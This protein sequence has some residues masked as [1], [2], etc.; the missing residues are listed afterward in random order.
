MKLPYRTRRALVTL[1]IIGLI[2]VLAAILIWAVWLLWLDRYVVYT[3]DGAVI[4]FSLSLEYP[5]GNHAQPPEQGESVSI[6]FN[7]GDNA[8]NISTE[9]A[10]LNGYYIDTKMLRDSYD[11]VERQVNLLPEYATVMIDMR[12]ADGYYYYATALGRTAAGIDTSKVTALL[13]YMFSHKLYVIAR[14]PAFR[15]SLY[16]LDHDRQGLIHS[17]GRYCYRDPDKCYWIDPQNDSAL[18]HLMQVV[19]ELKSLG[20]HEVVFDDFNYPNTSDIQFK[21]NREQVL[22]EAAQKLVNACMTNTFT[23]S[24]TVQD[25]TFALPN[26]RTR[27]YMKGQ[28][29]GNAQSLCELTGFEDPNIRLIFVTEVNDTRFDEYSVLRPLTAAELEEEED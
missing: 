11:L 28:S 10:A 19:A 21:G 5:E 9:L 2:L 4:D 20:F 27:I 17:S 14:I 6:Y 15:D 16:V 1:G 12:D 8:V 25:A 13:E 7:E 18:A 29:A 24:F 22:A 26:G 23:V 3:R